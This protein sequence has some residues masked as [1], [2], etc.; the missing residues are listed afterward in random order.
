M[1]VPIQAKNYKKLSLLHFADEKL[2]LELNASKQ[3]ILG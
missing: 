3:K 1:S 2:E